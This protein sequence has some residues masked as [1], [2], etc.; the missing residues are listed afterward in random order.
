MYLIILKTCSSSL[1]KDLR[2]RR[3]PNEYLYYFFL[4]EK[5]AELKVVEIV[6]SV[7]HVDS[8]L[9]EIN[10]REFSFTTSV[11]HGS[12]GSHILRFQ[13][14][15]LLTFN[16]R[17]SLFFDV[18]VNVFHTKLFFSFYFRFLLIEHSSAGC[19][20]QTGNE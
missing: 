18:F 6:C 12:V 14:F 10:Q 1:E 5:Y 15:F 11:E 8:N 4:F 19:P 7:Q 2:F 20:F 16:C 9:N 3:W 17:D 13:G